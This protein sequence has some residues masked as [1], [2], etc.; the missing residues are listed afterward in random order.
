LKAEICVN[1]YVFKQILFQIQ[2][3]YVEDCFL[4]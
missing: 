3:G 2:S 1:K 4:L